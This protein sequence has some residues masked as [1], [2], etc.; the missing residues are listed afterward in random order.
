MYP[1]FLC[2]FEEHYYIYPGMINEAKK[3]LLWNEL[4][5]NL[6][7][8][9]EDIIIENALSIDMNLES[10]DVGIED[11]L[12][13]Y[14]KDEY[15]YIQQLAKYL[16]QWVRTIRIR[17]VGRKTSQIDNSKEALYITFNYTAVLETVYKIALDKIIHIHGSLRERDSDPILGHG[18]KRRIERIQENKK[19]AER[20]FDE[21]W[22]SIC[23]VVEDYYNQT[24]KDV[25]RYTF[26]LI[27]LTKI[28]IEKVH[29]IG[30]S[31]AGVDQLYFKNIDIFTKRKAKWKVYYYK[32]D[33]RQKLYNNLLNCGIG[34]SRI[35]MVPS[36]QFYDMQNH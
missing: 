2:A 7:N 29:V 35:E 5:A 21:K 27:S 8:I 23:K 11:T 25:G 36:N 34:S 16:K 10:G 28:K 15:S 33:E 13:P 12:Y 1:E 18:N 20:L 24:Y 31:V 14:F 3:K 4:E 26:K 9:D 19:E 17:D 32:D 22:S 6:A 30:H